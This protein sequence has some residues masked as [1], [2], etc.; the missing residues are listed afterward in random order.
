MTGFVKLAS[1]TVRLLAIVEP[2]TAIPATADS[3]LK[4]DHIANVSHQ[5]EIDH[6]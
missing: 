6:C 5:R 4:P 3:D 1:Q 2:D